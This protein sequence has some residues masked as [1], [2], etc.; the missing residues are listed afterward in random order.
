MNKHKDTPKLIIEY[1]KLKFVTKL[2]S[3][4]ADHFAIALKFKN[5]DYEQTVY[6][7]ALSLLECGKPEQAIPHFKF[8]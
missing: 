7:L 6:N 4:A 5:I 3:E 1:A 2:F 8:F